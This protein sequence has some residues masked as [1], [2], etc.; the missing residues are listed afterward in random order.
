MTIPLFE[1]CSC[2]QAF[3]NPVDVDEKA[4]KFGY[5]Q[6]K[7]LHPGLSRPDPVEVYEC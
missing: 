3:T 6:S 1:N 7:L 4:W 5:L 2:V